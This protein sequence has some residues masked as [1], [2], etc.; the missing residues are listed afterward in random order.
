MF[1]VI[2]ENFKSKSFPRNHFGTEFDKDGKFLYYFH[3]LVFD[4]SGVELPLYLVDRWVNSKILIMLCNLDD[5]AIIKYS[6]GIRYRY[7]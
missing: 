2:K 7:W 1:V 5:L 6:W 4:E 3:D